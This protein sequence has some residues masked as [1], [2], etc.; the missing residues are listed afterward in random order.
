VIVHIGLRLFGFVDGPRSSHRPQFWIG[1]SDAVKLGRRRGRYVLP[2]LLACDHLLDLCGHDE[3]FVPVA[4]GLDMVVEML[5][6]GKHVCWKAQPAGFGWRV[7]R[8]LV[9][10]LA[11]SARNTKDMRNHS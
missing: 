3:E 7:M 9:V 5:Q 10:Q 6:A 2:G 11:L 8:Q 1:R 4:R